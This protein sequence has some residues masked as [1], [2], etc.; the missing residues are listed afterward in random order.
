[1]KIKTGKF[2]DKA[3]SRLTFFVFGCSVIVI[4][5]LFVNQ[6]SEAIAA[7]ISPSYIYLQ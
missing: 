5:L 6:R 3:S 2:K 1:M 4:G 7:N